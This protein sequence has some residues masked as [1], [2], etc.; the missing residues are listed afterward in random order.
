MCSVFRIE[1]KADETPIPDF[2]QT[3]EDPV[4]VDFSSARLMAAGGVGH[5]NMAQLTS[6]G[7]EVAAQVTLLKLHVVDIK[8]HF[9]KRRAYHG[10]QFRGGV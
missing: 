5:V 2:L 10:S 3:G 6:A 8:E 4:V 9:Q 7:P 1:L